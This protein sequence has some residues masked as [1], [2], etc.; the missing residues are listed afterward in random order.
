MRWRVVC[1]RGETITCLRPS[2][3]LSRVLL[4]A[5]GRPQ[6][7][8]KPDFIFDLSHAEARRRRVLCIVVIPSEAEESCKGRVSREKISRKVEMTGHYFVS[9]SSVVQLIEPAAGVRP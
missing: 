7:T 3:A 8:Q 5:L 9:A 2:S 6:R 1:G 4:P